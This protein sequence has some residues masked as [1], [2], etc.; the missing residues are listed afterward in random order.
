MDK[1]LNDMKLKILS[2]SLLFVTVFFSCK[3]DNELITGNSFVPLLSEVLVASNPLYIYSYNSSN[4][5]TEERSKFQITRYTYNEKDQLILTDYYWDNAILSSS[6]A[7]VEAA[8]NRKEWVTPANAVKNSSVNYEYDANGQLIK[9]TV[10]Q[11][12]PGSSEYS[13]FNYDGNNRIA[14][15]TINWENKV[16]G[17][18]DYLY[19]ASG[20]LISEILFHVSSTG[21]ANR[22]TST[23]YQYDNKQ[24]PYRSFNHLLEPGIH[25][26]VNNVIKETYTIYSEVDKSGGQVLVTNTSYDYDSMGYPKKTN[27]TVTFVYI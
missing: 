22:I 24:N 21:V 1:K 15:E 5:I 13:E 14:R 16:T 19:D 25:T 26:N 12:T 17:Y 4:L 11:L 7:D 2:L 23:E 8:M 18:N 9:T 27:G 3:K 10:N 6:L 20:N